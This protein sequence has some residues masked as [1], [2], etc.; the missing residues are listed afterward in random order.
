MS[1]EKQ[2]SFVVENG[3]TI[4][5]I[6]LALFVVFAVGLPRWLGN[7][8]D[9]SV[10][11]KTAITLPDA[12]G[13]DFKA[14]DL[15]SSFTAIE[16]AGQVSKS[17][18][19]SFRSEAGDL[20]RK[21]GKKTQT[22]TGAATSYRV[23]VNDDLETV[24]VQAQRAGG[25]GWLPGTGGTFQK[26]GDVVCYTVTSSSTGSNSVEC[27]RSSTDLTIDAQGTSSTTELA[28]IVDE[29]WDKVA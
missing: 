7:D 18:I 20:V 17:T 3:I 19:T 23:Y 1:N 29:V 14:A 25:S 11:S 16:K 15:S 10:L 4:G 9:A 13:K 22:A 28:G 6:A 12:V 27:R 5:V 24:L 21:E 26:K 8:A 2:Q